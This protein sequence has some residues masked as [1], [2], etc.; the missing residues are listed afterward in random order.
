MARRALAL[1]AVSV[2]AFALAGCNLI[3]NNG[4]GGAD[5]SNGASTDVFTISV[6]DCLNDSG[7]DD[8]VS[9]V[10]VVDC[11]Q[12]HDS[13]AYASVTLPDGD[14][15]GNESVQAQAV[16]QCTSE[17]APFI[18]IDYDQS[19]LD[20]AYYYPT[21]DSWDQGDREVLCLVMDPAGQTTGSLA[22][23]AR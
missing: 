8:Q 2:T 21:S 11:D 19:D 22:G 16:T 23:A 1:F 18:G 5:S 20:F 17:F 15:P 3:G 13:E 12:P 6:G 9:E 10:P 7:L 14:F 4:K